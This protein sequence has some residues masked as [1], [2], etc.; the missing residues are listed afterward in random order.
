MKK[1]GVETSL[2]ETMWD[3]NKR[4]RKIHDWVEVPFAV[5]GNE[6]KIAPNH[7]PDNAKLNQILA[8]KATE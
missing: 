2:L 8:S 5:E 3:Y 4:I 6:D 1:N 7:Q